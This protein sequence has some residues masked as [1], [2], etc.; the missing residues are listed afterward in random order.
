MKI[1]LAC[2]YSDP[3]PEIREMRVRLANRAAADLM[4]RGH[5]VFSPISHSHAI[6]SQCQLP[7]I[8]AFWEKQSHAF[9]EWCDEL[10]I[11]GLPGWRESRGV[12]AELALAATLG[13]RWAVVFNEV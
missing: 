7:M 5:V 11:L 13:K 10:R 1:Y 12:Q 4:R 6:A 2:P 9:V 3:D 8:W